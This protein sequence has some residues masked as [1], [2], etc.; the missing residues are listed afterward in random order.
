MIAPTSPLHPRNLLNFLGLSARK[1]MGQNFLVSEQVL[2]DIVRAAG[3]GSER[4]VLEVGPG[5][6]ALTAYLRQA[7]ATVVALEKDRGL[8]AHLEK[9][10]SDD[11]LVSIIQTDALEFDLTQ[12]PAGPA[13][14]VANLPYNVAIPILFHLLSLGTRWESLHLMVQKEVA[15]RMWAQA[16]TEAYGALSINLQLLANV[17]EVLEVPRGAFFP[18]PKVT[19]TVVKIVPR[20]KPPFDPGDRRIFDRMI[21]AAF[22]ERRKTLRNALS[23]LFPKAGVELALEQTGI[24]G[25]RRGETLNIEEFCRLSHAL[26]SATRTASGQNRLPIESE[27][28][29]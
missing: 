26:A 6:G 1:S 9:V 14:V 18:A 17:S 8:A 16:D 12:L 24:N 11:P 5:L 27:P 21:K 7:G 4:W 25:M 13:Q 2:E 23:S 19:S 15:E 28:Q 29:S 3:V 10:F 22:G 20:E